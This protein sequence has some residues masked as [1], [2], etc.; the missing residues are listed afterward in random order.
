MKALSGG[1]GINVSTVLNHLGVENIALGFVAGFTGEEI[2]NGFQRSGG[3]SD[4]IH[5]EKGLGW[6]FITLTSKSFVAS[7]MILIPLLCNLSIIF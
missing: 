5:L 7:T 1:K 3:K 6:Y 2:E 4:F